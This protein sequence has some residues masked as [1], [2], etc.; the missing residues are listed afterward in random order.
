MRKWGFFGHE[1]INRIATFT[2]PP[3]MFGFYKEHIEYLTEHAVDP[4]KRRYAVEGEAQRHYIDI[5]H[6]LH[7]GEDPFKIVPR[8]WEDAVAKFTEDTLQAYG[9][10]PWHILAMKYKLQRAFETKNVDLIL[11]YSADIGHYI[12]DA[13]V[14]LHTTENYNGQMTGQKGIHG[15]WESRLVEINAENYDYFIGKV[16]YIKNLNDYIWDIV[17][18]SNHAV[19]SV[20]RIEREVTRDFPSDRKYSF[21]RRGNSTVSVYSREFSDEYHRRMNGMV[22]RRLRDAILAVG[23]IWYTA[24]VDAGQPDL[25]GLQNIPPS[26][27]L[28]EEMRELDA[29]Y[30]NDTHKGRICE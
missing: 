12:G 10:V 6:Y 23:S 11:K 20:L 2:L 24:W 21:E 1:R 22:E 7:Y 4:D 17:E 18:E 14:P 19:D 13:H 5:D 26:A 30:H 15:L 27:E 25:S 9:I 28:L 8:R 3:E 16:K 29:H